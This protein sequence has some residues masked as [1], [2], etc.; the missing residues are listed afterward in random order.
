MERGGVGR[1]CCGGGGGGSPCGIC[2]TGTGSPNIRLTISGVARRTSP[3]I[4]LSEANYNDSF[5]FV[6][7][8]ACASGTP[9]EIP[10]IELSGGH[11]NLY[12]TILRDTGDNT[13]RISVQIIGATAPGFGFTVNYYTAALGVSNGQ[14][15]CNTS[16]VVPF[17]SQSATGGGAVPYEF[18]GSSVLYEILPP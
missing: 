13:P 7:L 4:Y 6:D 3:P 16:R 12:L 2:N 5:D 9:V 8:T 11:A 18:S 17:V 15:N 10:D 14:F 1:C